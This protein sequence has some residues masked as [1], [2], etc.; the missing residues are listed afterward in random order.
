MGLLV[1]AIYDDIEIDLVCDN[2]LLADEIGFGQPDVLKGQNLIN[3]FYERS[4][5]IRRSVTVISDKVATR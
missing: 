1:L 5:A 4:V 2:A 3:F